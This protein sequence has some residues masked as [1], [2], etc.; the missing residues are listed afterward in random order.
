MAMQAGCRHS[1]RPAALQHVF[2]IA[3][4]STHQGP[5]SK[6]VAAAQL[7]EHLGSILDL[8]RDQ[9]QCQVGG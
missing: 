3:H 1:T 8:F 2:C 7:A 5:L 4:L 9:K 6:V